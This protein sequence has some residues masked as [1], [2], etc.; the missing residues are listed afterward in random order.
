MNTLDIAVIGAGPYGLSIAAHLRGANADFRIFGTPMQTWAAEMPRGMRLK[1]EGMASSLYDPE[2]QLTLETYCKKNGLPYA[3]VGLPVP[4]DT[5]VAYGLEFQKRFVP[6]LEDKKVVSLKPSSAGYQLRLDDG[7]V[8]AA[9][10]VVVAV[11]L[12]YY[13]FVPPVLSGLPETHVTHCSK[14][15]TLDRF[16]GNEVIVVGAGASALDIAA[17]LHQAGAKVRVV[18]RAPVIRLWD[19]PA[20]PP[21]S[22]FQ[23]LR[24]PMSGLG[25]G[26]KL[27][28][29]AEA[30]L[31]FRLMSVEFRLDKVKRVLGPSPAWFIKKD[32]EGKVSLNPGLSIQNARVE[33]GRVKLD[34]ANAA[35]AGQTLEADH[36]IAATGYKVDLRR[37]PFLDSDLLAQIRSVENTPVLSSNFESSLRGLY[38]V[39]TSAAN[40]FGPLLRF[41]V[42]A[43]FTARRLSRHLARSAMRNAV[44]AGTSQASQQIVKASNKNANEPANIRQ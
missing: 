10:R 35:G 4:L 2:S 9:R 8:V 13:Q 25:R 40:T 18:A 11:G 39:G 32:I 17:L 29:C 37:L 23:W 1:S 44:R 7:E 41:A 30:P 27:F 5:F 38:F 43:K 20:P 15:R 24:E 31:I 21:A 34:V 16:K 12:S 36:I 42:G 14:H 22:L 19:P 6:Q 26:W 33:N 28:M 3:D